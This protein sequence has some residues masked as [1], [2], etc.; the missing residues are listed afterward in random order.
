MTPRTGAR[1]AHRTGVRHLAQ[2]QVMGLS[3]QF[4]LGMAVSHLGQPSQAR[5]AA[6]IASTVFLAAHVLIT[7]GLA[8]GRSLSSAPQLAPRTGGA[9]WPYGVQLPSPPPPRQAFSP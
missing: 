4:L 7:V 8:A 2:H 3:V 9:S 1:Q 6:H 5:G